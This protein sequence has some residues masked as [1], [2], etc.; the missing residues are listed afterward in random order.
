L[1]S[2]SIRSNLYLIRVQKKL[3]N[4]QKLFSLTFHFPRMEFI[5]KKIRL[6]TSD[7]LSLFGYNDSNLRLLEN[8]F[9]ASISVRGNTVLLKGE[10]AEVRTIEKVLNELQYIIR[11]TGTLST[12]DVLTVIDLVGLNKFGAKDTQTA[13]QGAF[14][15]GSSS[16]GTSSQGAFSQAHS[17]TDSSTA[18]MPLVDPMSGEPVI[19][20]AHGETI[21]ARTPTQKLYFEKVRT[22][23][24]VFAIGPAG[25]GKTYLAVAMAL[26]LLRNR[27]VSRLILSRPAVDAGE[28]LGFLPGDIMEK[29]DPYLRPLLDA[30]SDMVTPDKLKSM[31]EKRIVEIIPLA[32]MRGRTFNNSVIILDEAQNATTTQMKMFLTRMGKN[33]KLIVTGDITQIDLQRRSDSGLVQIQDILK[34]IQGIEYVYFD[35]A[36]VVRH[37]LVAEII[38]AYEKYSA[39]QETEREAGRDAGRGGYR[40][41]NRRSASESASIAP[42]VPNNSE[43]QV[44]EEPVSSN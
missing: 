35:K 29:V 25:T 16:H 5:E 15:H 20:L 37:R 1:K 21:K 3:K 36:D 7:T 32:Y 34:N 6:E 12:N 2:S 9:D 31:M 27:E 17:N 26:A 44:A 4:I 40:G 39:K 24:I 19:Y 43:K 33:S 28:S 38:D 10:P 23:D 8:N 13:S 42:A 11:R 22:N 14:S 41:D 30:L 18:S